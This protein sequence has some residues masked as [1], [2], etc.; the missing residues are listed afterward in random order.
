MYSSR[1]IVIE[2]EPG[3]VASDLEVSR[4]ATIACRLLIQYA[5]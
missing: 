1:G 4:P 3:A 5:A 2:R